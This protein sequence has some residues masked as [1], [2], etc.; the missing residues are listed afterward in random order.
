MSDAEP[1]LSVRD[2]RTQF[3]TPDGTV[4]AVDG[5]S[6]EV[7]TGETVCL[8]GESGSGKTVTCDSLAGL[9]EV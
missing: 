9:V 6:F 5:V 3:E 2:L 8:V 1:L 4:R 7:R